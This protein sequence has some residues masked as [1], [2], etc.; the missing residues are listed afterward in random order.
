MPGSR[1][2]GISGTR[3]AADISKAPL[4]RCLQLP[5][6]AGLSNIPFLRSIEASAWNKILRLRWRHQSLAYM[7][8]SSGELQPNSK[9]NE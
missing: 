9:L 8:A 6:S 4:T 2:L 5:S 3:D 7:A 1:A